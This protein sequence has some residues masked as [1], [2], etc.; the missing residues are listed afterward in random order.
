V[1][2]FGFEE[3][4]GTT[5]YDASGNGNHGTLSGA[6]RVTDKPFGRALRFDG[7]DDWVTIQDSNSL[8]LTSGM[9]LQAWVYPTSTMTNWRTVLM[10]EQTGNGTYFMYAN[11]ASNRPEGIV[12]V[13]GAE[14]ILTGSVTVQPKR[15]T[16]LAATYNGSTQQLYVN[17]VLVGSRPQAGNMIV[18]G[19]RLRIGGNAV[20]GE[21]FAGFIDEVRVY[22][23]ALSQAE[24][25]TDANRAVVALQMSTS[26]TRA[27]PVPLHGQ[28]VSGNIYIFYSDL[29]P[30]SGKN[31]VK[32]VKFWLN[33]PQ[34]ANPSGTPRMTENVAPFDFAGTATDGTAMPLNTAALPKGTHTVSAQAVLSDGTVLPVR[35]GTFVI[36]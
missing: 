27:S 7:V 19:G 30:S 18:S 13:D 8:D 23:R 12:Y 34:P 14:R 17:G 24:I 5:V 9:T 26:G 35:V 10:K 2:A 16:H 33:D 21:Y 1:A 36:P 25:A 22:N 32:Q 11:S 4:G 15:W 28:T 6:R 31:P 20:W 29:G 3:T